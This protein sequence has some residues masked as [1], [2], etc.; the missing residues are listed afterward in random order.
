MIRKSAIKYEHAL[1]ISNVFNCSFG[2]IHLYFNEK[3]NTFLI[4]TIKQIW[5]WMM[6]WCKPIS[7]KLIL[8]NDKHNRIKIWQDQNRLL[9]DE[10]DDDD[11]T[12]VRTMI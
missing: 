9:W 1:F 12:G 2:Y 5:G 11:E 10:G 4:A 3:K 6:A 7:I 8:Q